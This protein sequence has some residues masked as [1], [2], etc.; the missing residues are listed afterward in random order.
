MATTWLGKAMDYDVMVYE[1]FRIGG[2]EDC[3]NFIGSDVPTLQLV[4]ML[5]LGAW[6]AQI[7]RG[8]GLPQIID[9]TSNNK[10][11]GLGAARLYD[12][13][14]FAVIREALDGPHDQGHHGDLLTIQ[15]HSV[16]PAED[17]AFDLRVDGRRAEV[18]TYKDRA[19]KVQPTVDDVYPHNWD[20]LYVVHVSPERLRLLHFS[21]THAEHMLGARHKLPVRGGEVLLDV[22]VPRR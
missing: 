17:T 16:G 18:K 2:Q 3:K 1:R 12:P 9:Q 5:R 8:D 4:G 13:E 15:G 11:K 6:Q 7:H 19:R 22:E 10:Q 14:I 21:N 20:D